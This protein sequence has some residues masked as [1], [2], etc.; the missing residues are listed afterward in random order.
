[1]K[2]LT[3]VSS[4][5]EGVHEGVGSGSKA[6]LGLKSLFYLYLYLAQQH[7]SIYICR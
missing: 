5:G 2:S 3:T 1:M 6:G 4:F 7:F